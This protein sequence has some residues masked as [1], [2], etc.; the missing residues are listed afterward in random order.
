[1][2]STLIKSIILCKV[3]QTTWCVSSETTSDII[4]TK[5]VKKKEALLSSEMHWS[6]IASKNTKTWQFLHAIAQSQLALSQDFKNPLTWIHCVKEVPFV[7]WSA[8]KW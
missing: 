2:D 4:N 5:D 6:R 1:M 7:N 8:S 3:G